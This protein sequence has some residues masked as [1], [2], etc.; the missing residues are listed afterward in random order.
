MNGNVLGRFNVNIPSSTYT[1]GF[2]NIEITWYHDHLFYMMEV[3]IGIHEKK[4]I[5]E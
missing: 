3:P 1:P 4:D 5:L 2:I